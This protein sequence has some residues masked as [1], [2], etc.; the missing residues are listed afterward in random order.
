MLVDGYVL[1]L[2]GAVLARQISVQPLIRP[3]D[4][5]AENAHS[6]LSAVFYALDKSLG[7]LDKYYDVCYDNQSGQGDVQQSI[8]YFPIV[9]YTNCVKYNFQLGQMKNIAE[10]KEY[11]KITSVLIPQ[12]DSSESGR[13][14]GKRVKMAAVFPI[15]YKAEYDG[16]NVVIK[17]TRTYSID[18]HKACASRKYAP[19]VIYYEDNTTYQ[20]VIYEEFMGKPF[21][22]KDHGTNSTVI[23]NLTAALKVLHDKG[24]V[25]GDLRPPNILV[26]EDSNVNLIDFDWSGKAGVGRYPEVVNSGIPWPEGVN[27]GR[28]LEKCHDDEMFSKLFK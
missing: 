6:E 16:T 7:E 14:A 11:M 20:V 10:A 1:F 12:K 4:L 17:F 3:I 13:R 23:G 18:A 21:S 5:M 2:Y 26:N 27:Y 15:L 24:F 25:F 22:K 9:K 28:R 19:R 8:A